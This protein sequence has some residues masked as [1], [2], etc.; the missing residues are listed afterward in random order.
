MRF[1]VNVLFLASEVAGIIKSGGLADVAKAL[2][3]QLQADGHKTVVVMPCYSI[4][5]GADKF[6]VVAE[7]V[8]NEGN[9]NPHLHIPYSIRKT[10]LANSA[11]DL[12]L[13]DCPRYFDRTSLYGDNNQAYG[14]NGERYAFFCAAAIEACKKVEFKPDILHWLAHRLS[15]DDLKN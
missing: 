7:G 15:T 4:I 11:V 10:Q 14:D 2:P 13:I 3:L 6:P 12:L 5:P 1:K 9:P 8:L